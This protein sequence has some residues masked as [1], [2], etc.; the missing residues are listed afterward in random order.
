MTGTSRKN[1]GKAYGTMADPMEIANQAAAL[2]GERR[3]I[4]VNITVAQAV[5][6]VTGQPGHE[7]KADS[8]AKRAAVLM[9]ERAAVGINMTSAQ[10][11][12][13]VSRG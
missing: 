12:R 6:E 10:A 3:A 11:V 13:E 5:R 7:D 8:L 2:M 9:G 4:G 1:P